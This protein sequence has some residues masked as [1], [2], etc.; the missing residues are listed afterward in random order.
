[1][2]L[3]SITFK[4]IKHNIKN[5][6]AYFLEI[7]FV[8]CIIFMFSN[9][10]NSSSFTALPG[11]TYIKSDLIMVVA[12][13]TAFSIV[14]I[15]Y[16]TV[17]FTKFRGKEFGVY[18]TIG[19]TSKNII[20][21]LVCENAI[22]SAAAFIIGA[23]LGTIFSKLFFMA[24][25]K[26]LHLNNINLGISIKA[27]IFI[28]VITISIFLVNTV[29]QII[30][31]NRLSIIDIIK[32][33]SKR[34]QLTKLNSYL[35]II[36]LVILILAIL[37]FPRAADQAIRHNSQNANNV[38]A[39]C[40]VATIISMYFIIGF[41]M[42][43]VIRI[44]K[45]FK[46][47]YNS[48]IVILN[49]LL[50]R[51]TVY[52]GVLFL[53]TLFTAGAIFFSSLV[54]SMYRY[55]GKDIDNNYPYDLS[56]IS[57]K[58]NSIINFESIVNAAGGKIRSI[59]RLEGIETQKILQHNNVI[60]FH[61]QTIIVSESNYNKVTNQNIEIKQK[62]A[63]IADPQSDSKVSDDGIIIDYPIDEAQTP[64]LFN[65]LK[66]RIN[67]SAYKNIKQNKGFLYIPKEN[68]TVNKKPATNMFLAQNH[69]VRIDAIVVND[70]DYK[71]LKANAID[72][73]ISYDILVN[74]NNNSSYNLIKQNLT[75]SLNNISRQERI[76][77]TI[78]FKQE[79]FNQQ[80][81]SRGFDLFIFF[82]F[83][84]MLFM[85]SA[86]TLY[87]KTFTSLEEDK[88]RAKQ[89]I[90]IGLTRKEINRIFIKELGAVFILP[91]I[92]TIFLVG[93]YL[94]NIVLDIS[95]GDYIWNN[96]LIVFGI[97]AGIQMIFYLM[98]T[99]KYL[100]NI[101]DRYIH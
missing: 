46:S 89:L 80:I 31:I 25:I 47:F 6:I 83:G 34:K 40:V 87:F 28:A 30:F 8:I 63:V 96:C 11:T 65:L 85:G 50:H 41:F 61:G 70:E 52:R 72:D 59:N 74:L 92:A 42:S 39:F 54:F 20:K 94:S 49:A 64:R 16:A 19:L 43:L 17:S 99:N 18:Y 68:I 60:G 1:M 27:Y 56:F 23:T 76:G 5:Y 48:N 14:F 21:L 62:C 84:I 67:F 29:Y 77:D 55:T 66:S 90:K 33:N 4:N 15:S 24:I 37:E 32:I 91:P 44:S 9:L 79:K 26:I 93:Y 3:S 73:A 97:Y 82:F 51:F 12:L 53:V 75:K 35:G 95:G 69:H 86:A 57:E 101:Q 22:I 100:H 10:L 98:T 7:S 45:H 88:I 78:V 71:N 38:M 36:A 81:G 13:I 2:K 58:N